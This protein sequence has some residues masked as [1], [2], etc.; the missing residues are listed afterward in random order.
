MRG[1]FPWRLSDAGRPNMP[2]RHRCARH[3]KP[4]TEAAL[5]GLK[6]QLPLYSQKLTQFGSRDRSETRHKWAQTAPKASVAATAPARVVPDRRARRQGRSGRSDGLTPKGTR[7]P[8]AFEA[9]R[10]LPKCPEATD[11]SE[12][13]TRH[14]EQG[15]KATD[16][17]KMGELPMS[18]DGQSCRRENDGAEDQA[19][20]TGCRYS[21]QDCGRYF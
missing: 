18:Q 2:R 3:P 16:R 5:A 9:D 1:F 8:S 11:L 10:Q 21:D 6:L 20:C 13:P 4:F 7:S 12:N 19:C 15:G 17:S 14:Q